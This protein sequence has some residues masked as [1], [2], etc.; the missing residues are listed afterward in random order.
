V[1][2][3]LTASS[4]TYVKPKGHSLQPTG[5]KVTKIPGAT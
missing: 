1:S 4:F 5:L 2:P 3:G